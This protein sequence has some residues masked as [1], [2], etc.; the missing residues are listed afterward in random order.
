MQSDAVVSRPFIN[1]GLLLRGA[2]ALIAALA[3]LWL[4]TAFGSRP[5]PGPQA[6]QVRPISSAAPLSS[7]PLAAQGPVSAALGR[8]D[9][10]YWVRDLTAANPLNRL[11]TRFAA[12]AVTVTSARGHVRFAIPGFGAPSADANRIA[13]R[14]ANVTE[15][16]ANGPL[17]LEQ[18]FVVEHGSSGRIV[19]PMTLSGNLRASLAGGA[20]LLTG[21][22]TVLR[23]ERPDRHRRARP[24]PARHARPERAPPDR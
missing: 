16:Y 7:L 24:P 6:A 17:G 23:Y 22:G 15:T 1:A 5:A 3:G 20:L 9:G 18:S 21:A 4:A 14:G 11:T 19:I 8:A 2:G 12:G 13:Y 10:A